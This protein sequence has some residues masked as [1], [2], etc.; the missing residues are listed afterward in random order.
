MPAKMHA[1]VRLPIVTVRLLI[2]SFIVDQDS[3]PMLRVY[4]DPE[5]MRFI[6]GGALSDIDAV[7][8]S[9]ETHVRAQERV[10][11]APG[12]SSSARRAS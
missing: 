5:V 2:R 8:S 11:S 7:R 9:L 10:V 4:G 3:G 1:A 12:L 6:P